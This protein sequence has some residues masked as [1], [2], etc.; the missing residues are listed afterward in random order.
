MTFWSSHAVQNQVPNI[1]EGQRSESWS[2]F[3]D[4]NLQ[5]WPVRETVFALCLSPSGQ[6]TFLL[7]NVPCNAAS[8]YAVGRM[9]HI[10]WDQS[11]LGAVHNAAMATFFDIYE[12]VSDLCCDQTCQPVIHSHLRR[13]NVKEKSDLVRVDTCWGPIIDIMTSCLLVFSGFLSETFIRVC[14]TVRGFLPR[15][16]WCFKGLTIG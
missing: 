8:C 16:L 11:D 7:E 12:D 6:Q 3:P 10:H 15:T 1:P 13:P 9:F 14:E 4:N 5:K 2:F